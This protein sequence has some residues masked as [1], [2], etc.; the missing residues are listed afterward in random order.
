MVSLPA[1]ERL[2]AQ[3]SGYTWERYQQLVGVDEW[4]AEE[5]DSK[6]SVVASYRLHLTLEGLKWQSG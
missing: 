5:G 1:E 3:W 2:A 4:L 6:A